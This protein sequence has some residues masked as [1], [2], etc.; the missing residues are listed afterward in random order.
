VVKNIPENFKTLKE[1]NKEI[2]CEKITVDA[3]DMSLILA[4]ASVGQ[5]LTAP[6]SGGNWLINHLLSDPRVVAA[7]KIAHNVRK[8]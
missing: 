3:L 1:M 2:A 8:I 6:C 4:Y 7:T 5:A